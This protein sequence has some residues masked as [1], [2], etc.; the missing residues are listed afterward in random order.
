MLTSFAPVPGTPW[1]LVQEE[2]WES[3]MGATRTYGQFLLVL[4][5]LGV[6]VP[7]AV[8]TLGVGRVTRPV[9]QLL[10]G[11]RRIA[12]GQY[13]QTITLSTGDELEDLVAQF[14][15][16]SLSL[17]E[18]YA[19]LEARVATRTREL[20]ALNTIAAVASKSLYLEET[21]TATLRET[22]QTVGMEAGAAFCLEEVKGTPRC[23][24]YRQGLS[25]GGPRARVG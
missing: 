20:A 24:W 19:Q 21:L 5:G 8:V 6:L 17:E 15:R 4:L 2:A 22:L 3:L 12:N 18:S 1:G 14:N 9:G 16:M 25:D 13:G 23:D 11:A 7:A 10:E